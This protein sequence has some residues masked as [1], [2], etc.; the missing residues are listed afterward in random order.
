MLK[1]RLAL[2][3]ATIVHNHNA[4]THFV[5]IVLTSVLGTAYLL[6]RAFVGLI[7]VYVFTVKF[8]LNVLSFFLTM[9]VSFFF[10]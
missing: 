2:L 3:L 6:L 9:P 8:N 4:L 5:Q 7:V 10:L 1:P